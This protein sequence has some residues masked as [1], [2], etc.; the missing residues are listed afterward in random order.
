MKSKKIRQRTEAPPATK[1]QSAIPRWG[2]IAGGVCAVIIAA[3]VLYSPSLNGPFVFDDRYLPFMTPAFARLSLKY[4]LGVRP[5][6]NFSYWLTYQTSGLDSF[7]YH[8]CNVILHALNSLLV[9]VIVRKFLAMAGEA[10]RTRDVLAALA[11][12]VFLAHPVQTEAVA[13]VASRSETLSFFFAFSAFAVYLYTR[14]KGLRIGHVV[15]VLLLFVAAMTTKEHTLALPAVFIATDLFWSGMPGLKRNRLLYGAILVGV[16][17]GGAVVWNV[18]KTSPMIGFNSQ[19]LTWYQYLFTQFRAI[20]IYVRLFLLPVGLN[21]DYDMPPSLSIVDH[22]AII[23]LALLLALGFVAWKYR[24][25]FPLAAYGYLIFL[26]LLAPTSSIVPIRD[27]IAE[28]RL[29]LPSIGLLLIAVDLL[30]HLRW[31]AAQ[32]GAVLGVLLVVLGVSTFARAEV[33]N[34]NLLLWQDSVSKSPN[35]VRPRLQLAYFQMQSGNCQA[36]VAEYETASR[37]A[38]PNYDLLVNWAL[39]LDCLGQTDQ[40]L[41]KL[42]DAEKLEHPAHLY[43]TMGMMLGKQKHNSEALEALNKA[44]AKNP[45]FPMTYLYRGNVYM[46]LGNPA[47]ALEDYRRVMALDPSNDAARQSAAIAEQQ[48]G[49]AAR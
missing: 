36:A 19:N 22:L 33:W 48:M 41:A 10:G 9:F 13:Y 34:D 18:L 47:R 37:L 6:L 27:V 20:C 44:E 35:K 17:I 43:A 2:Y 3:F 45:K 4:W 1:P 38:T 21:V 8:A 29:Y 31:S 49:Q 24:R 14:E 12:V 16:V 39:A 5:L 30:R 32:Y 11:G 26:I 7:P 40:A 15:L 42:R 25:E 23:W 46:Q 28:R